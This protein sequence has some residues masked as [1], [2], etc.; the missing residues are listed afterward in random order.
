MIQPTLINLHPND[1][2]HEYHY[3]PFLVVKLYRCFGSVNTLKNLSNKVCIENKK[4]LNLSVLN[5]ITSINDS[6]YYQSMCHANINAGLMKK[7]N[8]SQW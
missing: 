8:S 1:Y 7:C 4:D 2:S 3:N 6:K 5:M